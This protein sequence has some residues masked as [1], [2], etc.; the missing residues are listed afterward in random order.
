MTVTNKLPAAQTA[1]A[2]RIF[3]PLTHKLFMHTHTHTHTH[4]TPLVSP[5]AG[6]PA[7][8]TT[9]SRHSTALHCLH[10]ESK[11]N[12]YYSLLCQRRKQLVKNTHDG[13]L[14]KGACPPYPSASF[15]IN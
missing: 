14:F 4:C 1:V 7:Y 5:Q 11:H 2:G 6:G 3:C 8:T 12:S 15:T 10:V 9:G 13:Q